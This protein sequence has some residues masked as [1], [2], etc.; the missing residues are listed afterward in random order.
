MKT[1]SF[2]FCQ[3]RDLELRVN[4][5]S[6]FFPQEGAARVF[7]QETKLHDRPTQVLISSQNGR[8]SKWFLSK[9]AND[10]FPKQQKWDN[11]F[12]SITGTP[13]PCKEGAAAIDTHD[14]FQIKT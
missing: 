6:I 2:E 13:N 14:S 8:G 4:Y 11:R 10:F 9:A 1:C 3:H 12:I 7:I 5:W